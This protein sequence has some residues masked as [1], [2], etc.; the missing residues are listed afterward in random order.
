MR[1][2]KNIFLIPLLFLPLSFITTGCGTTKVEATA[3]AEASAEAEAQ[4]L[5]QQKIATL[6]KK[7]T[8][9]KD[10]YNL[11]SYQAVIIDRNQMILQ[12]FEGVR[13]IESP[14]STVTVNDIYYLGKN[15][16]ILTAL[17]TAQLIDLKVLNWNSTL[18]QMI[19]KDFSINSKLK[20]VTIEMLLAQRSGLV[21]L[22]KLKVMDTLDKYSSRRGRA[23]VVQSI[24]SYDPLF[25]PDTRS[26][27][28]SSS[29]VVLG[30]ILEK[31]TNFAWEE[32]AKNK[33]FLDMGMSS[34]VFGFPVSKNP[35]AID[36]PQGHTLHNLKTVTSHATQIPGAIASAE[37][38]SCSSADF[39]KLLK[40]INSGLFRESSLLR[41]E[42]FTKLFGPSQ[43]SK[44]TYAH[45]QVHDRLWAGGQT[46]TSTSLDAYSTSL[47]VLAPSREVILLVTVNSGTPKAREGAAKILKLLTE[48][49]Q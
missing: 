16:K 2:M 32:L 24:L 33:L 43:D 7:L 38:L 48:F 6:E 11:P 46:L 9:I 10:T 37:G 31:Y 27:V 49:V 17:L 22:E 3:K 41:E 20:N 28:N 4:Q 15:S 45:F 14:T 29:Y 18:E 8:Q 25:A 26:D 1:N 12:K 30:W 47:A 21:P 13:A 19:G 35:K 36:H 40:E 44:L 34:C 39:I 5:K 23:L 42:T